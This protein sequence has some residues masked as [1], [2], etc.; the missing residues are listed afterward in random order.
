MNI[1]PFP[2]AIPD[3]Y[4]LDKVPEKTRVFAELV[5]GTQQDYKFG[6]GEQEAYYKY[7]QTSRFARTKKKGGW[8]CLRHYEIL[9][10]GC[11]P[12]F[13]NLQHCP[14]TTM[15]TFPKELVLHA[16]KDLLPWEETPERI[17]LY[18]SYVL[19]LLEHTRTYCTI[20]ALTKR[21]ISYMPSLLTD[22]IPD[23]S[24][25]VLMINGCS[26]VNYSRELLSIGLREF[27]GENFIEYPRNNILYTDCNTK[28]A[29]GNGY[30]YSGHLDSILTINRTNIEDRIV[31]HE[32]DVVL[33][34][35]MGADEGLLGTCRTAVLFEYVKNVY[36]PDTTA[37]LYGGDGC[38]SLIT[39]WYNY[40]LHLWEH[41]KLGRCFV[42]ELEYPTLCESLWKVCHP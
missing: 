19:K 35:K 42:R 6:Q 36:T 22:G 5:P 31:Q 39:H 40:S 11:I 15:V 17:T 24:K 13:E 3:K 28:G 9:M 29:Y 12:V 14:T 25:K 26:A 38:Q 37:F 18:N 20:S 33:Y 2:Y 21:F 7:Y 1:I 16:M 30:T 8:D 34:G 10:N 32:F 4:V 41:T 27:Y 23:P